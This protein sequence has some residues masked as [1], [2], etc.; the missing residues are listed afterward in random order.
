MFG[1]L[2]TRSVATGQTHACPH[3]HFWMTLWY[4]VVATV[5]MTVPHKLP[6]VVETV[7]ARVRAPRPLHQLN[8][9]YCPSFFFQ[10]L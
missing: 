10:E 6:H 8:W 5:Y 4:G 3:G 1:C 2:R 9:W 7:W